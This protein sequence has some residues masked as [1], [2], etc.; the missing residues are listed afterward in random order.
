M[1]ERDGLEALPGES[2]CSLMAHGEYVPITKGATAGAERARAVSGQNALWVPFT[3]QELKSSWAEWKAKCGSFKI[4]IRQEVAQPLALAP[5][6]KLVPIPYTGLYVLST[7]SF[8][9]L[10]W[11]Q[12]LNAE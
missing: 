2:K 12:L 10:Q 11:P 1:V 3:G 4:D 5:Q 8:C 7:R 6:W 9:P